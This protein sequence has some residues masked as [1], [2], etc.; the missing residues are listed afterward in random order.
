MLMTLRK[1]RLGLLKKHMPAFFVRRRSISRLPSGESGGLCLDAASLVRTPEGKKALRD[2]KEGDWVVSAEISPF[3]NQIAA[4]VRD[5]KRIVEPIAIRINEDIICSFS[6][7]LYVRSAHWVGACNIR[8]GM[9]ILR[10]DG[11][12]REVFDVVGV[13]GPFELVSFT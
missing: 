10:G 1:S 9:R 6:Q 13:P 11:S 8:P 3:N 2:L 12:Y 7:R 4:T 5:V